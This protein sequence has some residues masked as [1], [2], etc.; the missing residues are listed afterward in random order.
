MDV[1]GAVVRFPPGG[2]ELSSETSRPALEPRERLTQWISAYVFPGGG[3][4][5]RG[6]KLITW[7]PSSAEVEN[8]WRRTSTPPYVSYGVRRDRFTGNWLCLEK[9]RSGDFAFTRRSL[10]VGYRR[11]GKPYQSHLQTSSALPLKIGPIDCPLTSVTN[12]Q[13]TLRKI[14]EERR[15][16]LP[17]GRSLLYLKLNAVRLTYHAMYCVISC[18]LTGVCISVLLLIQTPHADLSLGCLIECICMV[19]IPGSRLLAASFVTMDTVS[20]WFNTC[21]DENEITYSWSSI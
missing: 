4:S 2:S 12:Y 20:N 6:V 8:E 1:I 21:G 14:P 19:L 5:G 18:L 15:P 11:F 16:Y 7:F 9:L 3:C 10:V 17:C 13:P